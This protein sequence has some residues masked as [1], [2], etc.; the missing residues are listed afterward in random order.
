MRG[1][2]VSRPLWCMALPVG[3]PACPHYTPKRRG[4]SNTS[5]IRH[6]RRFVLDLFG[7]REP[8]SGG[9][10][11][12]DSFWR[13][14]GP[15]G[16]RC[17]WRVWYCP[18]CTRRYSVPKTRRKT[19]AKPLHRDVAAIYPTIDPLDYLEMSNRRLV[20]ERMSIYPIPEGAQI[21]PP[22]YSLSEQIPDRQSPPNRAQRK[23]SAP[24]HRT[25]SGQLLT[26]KQEAFAQLIAEGRSKSAAYRQAYNAEK[27]GEQAVSHAAWE[28]TRNP[29]VAERIQELVMLRREENSA[30]LESRNEFVLRHLTE[31]AQTAKSEAARIRALQ[32]LGMTVGLFKGSDEDQRK[33]SI[34]G[35]EQRLQTLLKA[36]GNKPN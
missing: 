10:F 29:K 35:L 17:R 19:A 15:Q 16:W 9:R 5:N 25:H 8:I 4:L 31:L 36:A 14:A 30:R 26:E 28:L 20:E 34:A 22:D 7:S 23:R 13:A 1:P 6:L 12:P 32:L 24:I 33:P 21:A 11:V 18:G 3:V 2:G 27:M